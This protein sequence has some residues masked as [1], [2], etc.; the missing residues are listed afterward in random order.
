MTV[1]RI[2]KIKSNFDRKFS[3]YSYSTP[4]T[5][6]ESRNDKPSFRARLLK[7]WVA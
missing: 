7:L 3:R 6:T 1:S 2:G 5:K 4:T